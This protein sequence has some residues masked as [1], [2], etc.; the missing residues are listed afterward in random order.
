[1]E[2]KNLK[3]QGI[4]HRVEEK[5]GNT[6]KGAGKEVGVLFCSISTLCALRSPLFC[7]LCLVFCSLASSVFLFLSFPPVGAWPF[8]WI[9][10]VPL[11]FLLDKGA[12]KRAAF[13]WSYL[14]GFIFFLAVLQWIHFVTTPGLILLA[15]YLALY[16]GMFGILYC[17]TSRFPAGFRLFLI[18]AGWIVLEYVRGTAL[19]GFNWGSLGHSQAT[20]T[21]LIA[22]ASFAGVS[23]VS[24]LVVLGNVMLQQ[25]V[26]AYFQQKAWK[27]YVIP[28]TMVGI[29]VILAGIFARGIPYTE[30]GRARAVKVALIQ[31]NISLADAWHPALK[32]DIV[33][34][35][36]EMSQ[37]TLSDKPDLIIWPENSF[38]SFIWELPELFDEVKAFARKNKVSLLIG[39]VTKEGDKYF[40]SALLIWPNG[41]VVKTHSKRHLVLFGEYIP[42]RKEFPFLSDIVPIDDFTPGVEETVFELPNGIKFSVLVC[43]EDT[44]PEL[45]RRYVHKSA[46]FLVNMTNDAWFRDSGQPRTHLNNAIFRSV[47]NGRPLIRATNTGESCVVSKGGRVERCVED[48]NRRRVLVDGVAVATVTLSSEQT[49]YTKYGEI[50]TFLCF[51]GI[52]GALGACGLD[53]RKGKGYGD[54]KKDSTR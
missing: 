23:G 35:Q 4:G 3:I 19:T 49:F 21:G 34:W 27:W 38:P 7:I 2:N 8:A 15:A 20:C 40:N 18:P 13:G 43:F 16:F 10:L 53:M 26:L 44:I 42:F 14:T 5:S 30:V 52:L 47:E 46:D 37:Q 12:T 32:S 54:D 9:S 39:A 17:W 25:I 24:F 33:R 11:F 50:F 51:L 28:M 41:E 45:A 1:M 31:P 48:L 29:V 6:E 36:I 22:V